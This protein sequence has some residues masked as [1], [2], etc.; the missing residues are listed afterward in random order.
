[1]PNFPNINTLTPKT[2]LNGN[3]VIQISATERTTLNQIVQQLGFKGILGTFTP[4]TPEGDSSI[5]ISPGDTILEALQKIFG[6]IG[7]NTL[8]ISTV[9]DEEGDT[10]ARIV[11]K[12]TGDN[13]PETAFVGG[14]EW[15]QNGLVAAFKFG[16]DTINSPTRPWDLWD[17]VMNN[18]DYIEFSRVEQRS[19][20]TG[21]ISIGPGQIVMWEQSGENV[22]LNISRWEPNSVKNPAM[23]YSAMLISQGNILKSQV[24]YTNQ[25]TNTVVILFS[26]DFN[27]N[28][29][30]PYQCVTIQLV[31]TEDNE[32]VFLVNKC[33]Y[34]Q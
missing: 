33:G 26:D 21:A 13:V 24:V 29:G 23:G 17:W 3:E 14:L 2:T 32:M 25:G 16:A 19:T 31:S 20:S 7:G 34:S 22:S 15:G 10:V 12:S 8:S 11:V 27:S 5:T 4:V 1:M 18:G 6:R 30:L 28:P 9:P